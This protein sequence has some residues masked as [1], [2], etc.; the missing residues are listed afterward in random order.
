MGT[1]LEYH[2]IAGQ[3]LPR[4]QQEMVAHPDHLRRDVIYLAIHHPMGHTWGQCFELSNR[5]RGPPLRIPLE[6]LTAGLHEDYNEPGERLSKDQSGDDGQHG[7]EIGGKTASEHAAQGLPDDRR[8]GECQPGAPQ[9]GCGAGPPG[10][11]EEQPTQNEKESAGGKEIETAR[12]A[13]G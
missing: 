5:L 10:H 9:H 13:V 6:C 8:A 4:P 1:A 12:Q 2:S 7:H 3:Q 11:M